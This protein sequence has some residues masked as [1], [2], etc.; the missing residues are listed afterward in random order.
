MNRSPAAFPQKQESLSQNG[1]LIQRISN[2]NNFFSC[3][4]PAVLL[5]C[6][7]QPPSG[8]LSRPQA[9]PPP[10]RK[11]RGCCSAHYLA[12]SL[13]LTGELLLLFLLFE[14][15]TSI[16]FYPAQ[17]PSPR[18]L[19]PIEHHVFDNQS[20]GR[21][22][23]PFTW[24]NQRILESRKLGPLRGRQGTSWSPRP[25]FRL[26]IRLRGG[27]CP[28]CRFEIEAKDKMILILVSF[29]YSYT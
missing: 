20:W 7:H 12:G 27:R 13:L 3:T 21:E 22:A 4:S 1:D 28:D 6:G 5:F 23:H 19:Q 11:G 10:G 2:N 15:V 26:R 14:L 16:F 29:V 8:H 18:Y 17:D 24:L 9:P 25:P